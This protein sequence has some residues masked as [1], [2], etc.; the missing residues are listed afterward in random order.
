MAAH[1]LNHQINTRVENWN[2][3]VNTLFELL[4]E[5]CETSKTAAKI[6]AEAQWIDLRLLHGLA[7]RL[8]LL[9]ELIK[10]ISRD[11]DIYSKITLPEG[12]KLY[13]FARGFEGLSTQIIDADIRNADYNLNTLSGFA[14]RIWRYIQEHE[15][16]FR[17]VALPIQAQE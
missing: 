1:G 8:G 2:N 6:F 7:R 3:R 17:N 9:L 16:A 11:N 10:S 14:I 4:Y 12:Q 15:Q 13:D 5:T